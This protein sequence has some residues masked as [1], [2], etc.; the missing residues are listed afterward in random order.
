MA[1]MLFVWGSIYARYELKKEADIT[2]FAEGV[3]SDNPFDFG[4][5]Q[6]RRVEDNRKFDRSGRT[7]RR[8]K[9]KEDLSQYKEKDI[10]E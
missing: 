2:P 8:R 7:Q 5:G 4:S 1:S 6:V 3:E 10:K 9:F